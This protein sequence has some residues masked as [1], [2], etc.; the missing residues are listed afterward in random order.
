M[1]TLQVQIWGSPK[2]RHH[3]PLTIL[4]LEE[5]RVEHKWSSLYSH[6]SLCNVCTPISF[7][8]LQVKTTQDVAYFLLQ[9][10]KP[11]RFRLYFLD[12]VGKSHSQ[13]QVKPAGI[14]FRQIVPSV[15]P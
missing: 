12:Q 3:T 9:P 8:V 13:G 10:Q 6:G 7:K 15:P 14:N 1:E 4:V 2:L 5:A 11:L